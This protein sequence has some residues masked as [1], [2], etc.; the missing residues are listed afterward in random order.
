MNKKY[1]KNDCE[2]IKYNKH[3][4]DKKNLVSKDLF[5]NNVEKPLVDI[6]TP[7][8]DV[9]WSIGSENKYF[10]SPD[11]YPLS[12]FEQF[13]HNIIHII[14]WIPV[15]YY[16]YND[17]KILTMVTFLFGF[18]TIILYDFLKEQNFYFGIAKF[19]K[20]KNKKSDIRFMIT[21]S[22]SQQDG[23]SVLGK[24]NIYPNTSKFGYMIKSDHFIKN[25]KKHKIPL[26]GMEKWYSDNCGNG[27]NIKNITSLTSMD[28]EIILSA[29]YILSSIITIEIINSRIRKQKIKKEKIHLMIFIA[30]LTLIGSYYYRLDFTAK[31]VAL[32]KVR[33][34]KL[35]IESISLSLLFCGI[36]LFRN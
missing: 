30:A 27:D 26:E 13:F 22:G 4:L 19:N 6:I 7:E 29:F 16:F 5:W 24:N 36:T 33:R 34:D 8:K 2:P 14:F 20:G 11:L 25:V 9:W 21:R 3:Y 12:R 23:T 31:D 17:Y 15:F 32:S 10:P 28:S 1:N 18:I 35:I